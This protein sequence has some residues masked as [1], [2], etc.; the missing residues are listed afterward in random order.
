MGGLSKVLAPYNAEDYCLLIGKVLY[1]L[2]LRSMVHARVLYKDG[3]RCVLPG[4]Y[5]KGRSPGDFV[6]DLEQRSAEAVAHAIRRELRFLYPQANKIVAVLGDFKRP[7]CKVTRTPRHSA[8]EITKVIHRRISGRLSRWDRAPLGTLLLNMPFFFLDIAACLEGVPRQDGR[9]PREIEV[10]ISMSTGDDMWL[11]MAVAHK[12]VLKVNDCDGLFTLK[13]DQGKVQVA[14][15]KYIRDRDFD[16]RE[17]GARTGV[18]V[19]DQCKILERKALARGLPSPLAFVFFA[20]ALGDHDYGLLEQGAESFRMDVVAETVSQAF[21]EV[22]TAGPGRTTRAG[23]TVETVDGIVCRVAQYLA[24]QVDE[25]EKEVQ[26]RL[27][28]RRMRLFIL[29]VTSPSQRSPFAR[30]GWGDEIEILGGEVELSTMGEMIDKLYPDTAKGKGKEKG[31]V[32]ARKGASAGG[33]RLKLGAARARAITVALEKLRRD[34]DKGKVKSSTVPEPHL[35]PPAGSS[36][37][38]SKSVLAPGRSARSVDGLFP[39]AAPKP[40]ALAP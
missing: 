33:E 39:S 18:S 40:T 11:E 27:I 36:A 23:L 8:M 32:T 12:G 24:K 35:R 30:V 5:V 1:I 37:E 16:V 34:A 13:V 22:T 14:G 17:D 29:S 19:I 4:P 31:M 20:A 2:D 3:R 7:A 15:V 38:R 28:E 6:F 9:G 26:A 25:A 10:Q 21:A